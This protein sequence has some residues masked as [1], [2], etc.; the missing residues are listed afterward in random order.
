MAP[1]QMRKA[2]E[3]HDIGAELAPGPLAAS[4]R[5]SAREIEE[6]ETPRPLVSHRGP[7]QPCTPARPRWRCSRPPPRTLLCAS[8]GRSHSA[9]SCH[10]GPAGPAALMLALVLTSSG[11]LPGVRATPVQPILEL[12]ANNAIY[13]GKNMEYPIKIGLDRDDASIKSAAN[14]D[15]C[16]FDGPGDNGLCAELEVFTAPAQQGKTTLV[17]STNFSGIENKFVA[18][19]NANPP[20]DGCMDVDLAKQL[21][22]NHYLLECE[23]RCRRRSAVW[24]AVMQEFAGV[25]E[26]EHVLIENAFPKG[27]CLLGSHWLGS[28]TFDDMRLLLMDI[29]YITPELDSTLCADP[30]AMAALGCDTITIGVKLTHKDDERSV[31]RMVK[32]TFSE[33]FP[34]LPPILRGHPGF[35]EMEVDTESALN[36]F[37]LIEPDADVVLLT[38]ET[39]ALI[40]FSALRAPPRVNVLKYEAPE[41]EPEYFA[42]AFN[43]LSS[44]IE[45]RCTLE[46]AKRALGKL[47]FRTESLGLHNVTIA[48]DDEG[49]SGFPALGPN[50]RTELKFSV[51]TKPSLKP[52]TV[53]CV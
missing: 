18:P 31:N 27:R 51:L 32:A 29:G 15:Q 9:M 37:E 6:Q 14:P 4:V 24:F 49:R 30:G 10:A 42:G 36:P 1:A 46:Q 11:V 22:Q 12:P 41:Y 21:F 2:A 40:R 19:Q 13:G 33:E 45:V 5:A 44:K 53:V 26:Y 20:W 16:K 17:I 25:N 38:L 39:T 52:P 34:N 48:V 47:F 3:L 43:K 7:G 35:V 8:A 50:W 28:T 23:L